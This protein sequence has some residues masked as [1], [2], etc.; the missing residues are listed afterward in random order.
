M[1]CKCG[2]EIPQKR[3][4]MGYRTCTSCSTEHRWTI[5]PVNY[6]KTGNTAEIIKDPEVAADFLF[7]SQ[8]KN[9]GVLR[10]MTSSRSRKTESVHREKRQIQTTIPLIK[11]T[12][13]ERYLPEYDFENVGLETMNILES[14][15][16]ETAIIHIQKS[17]EEKRIFK[18]QADRLIEIV[19]NMLITS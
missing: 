19:H 15:G 9:F 7:Q 11:S 3:F 8:R 12:V 16:A 6:H 1:D 18:K 5:V 10:G 14:K 2:S 17:L 4:E 13:K